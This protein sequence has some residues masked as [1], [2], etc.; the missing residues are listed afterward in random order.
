M[1]GMNNPRN[2]PRVFG[3]G[4]LVQGE[5]EETGK[6]NQIYKRLSAQG[7][8]NNQQNFFKIKKT[9]PTQPPTTRAYRHTQE[10]PQVFVP[11]H[12]ALVFPF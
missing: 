9:P 8:G 7:W 6:E 4:S 11:Q 3:E 1:R 10:L 5:E 2:I 12:L